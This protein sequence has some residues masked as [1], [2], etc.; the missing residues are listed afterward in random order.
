VVERDGTSAEGGVVERDGTSA[1]GGVV[2]RRDVP[3]RCIE[4]S[5]VGTL[6]ASTPNVGPIPMAESMTQAA[7]LRA[8]S[9]ELR[10]GST[11]GA[12]SIP[13][14]FDHAAGFAGA[15]SAH[16]GEGLPMGARADHGRSTD[17]PPACAAAA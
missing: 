12:L 15:L 10:G 1:E 9:A 5:R 14:V 2:E 6:C 4:S 17:H 13:R 16:R 7:C 8:G 11:S 3:S